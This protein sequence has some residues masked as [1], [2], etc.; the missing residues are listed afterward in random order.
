MENDYGTII[1]DGVLVMVKTPYNFLFTT[2]W[3]ILIMQLFC[4]RSIKIGGE[5]DSA[6]R[7][8]KRTGVTSSRGSEEAGC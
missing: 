4:A 5:T 2:A 6:I 8:R 1:G 3:G 7:L